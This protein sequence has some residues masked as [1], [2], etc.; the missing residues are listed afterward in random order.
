MKYTAASIVIA[1][2]ATPALADVVHLKDGTR[3]DGDVKRGSSG[4]V[5]LTPDGKV[6]LIPT[7]QVKS[8]ELGA[9]SGSPDA[10]KEKLAS[11]RRSV[12][13]LND[14]KKIIERYHSFIEQ[15]SGKGVES[16]ARKDLTVW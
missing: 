7:D 3:L 10:Y 16:E 2:L 12:E 9:A 5:L 14:P 1:L 13:Y 8:I 6:Q 4:Y 15:N 11:L